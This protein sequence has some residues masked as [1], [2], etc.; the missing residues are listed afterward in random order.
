MSDK[1]TI[2]HDR[3]HQLSDIHHKLTIKLLHISG[4]FN[5]QYI[6]SSQL[7]E[8]NHSIDQ[9]IQ[10]LKS[11]KQQSINNLHA[12]STLYRHISDQQHSSLPIE[13]YV[14]C[15][16]YTYDKCVSVQHST[17]L[18]ICQ[19]RTNINCDQFIEFDVNYADIN[20]TSYVYVQVY[21]IQHNYTTQSMQHKCI[22]AGKFLL[23]DTNRSQLK[24]GK[25]RCV[26]YRDRPFDDIPLSPA[27]ITRQL[28]TL[29]HASTSNGHARSNS[30]NV[31]TNST[32]ERTRQ[33]STSSSQ[34]Q[35]SLIADNHQMD[36]YICKLVNHSLYDIV[37]III[38]MLQF[39]HNVLY[40]TN[41]TLR[42]PY[43]Q[44]HSVS[45]TIQNNNATIQHRIPV[46]VTVQSTYNVQ[47]Q[48]NIIHDPES[49]YDNT[50]ELM[51]NKLTRTSTINAIDL[52]PNRDER[53]QLNNII[54]S[55]QRRLTLDEKELLWRFRY[56]LTDNKHAL[57]KFLHCVNWN[58]NNE[59]VAACTLLQQWNN[60]IIEIS[61]LLEILNNTITTNVVVRQ[62][63]MNQ[64]QRISDTE[65]KL[66]LLQLIQACQ[67]DSIDITQP[68]SYTIVQNSNTLIS[69]L[70]QR[71]SNTIE[72]AT[73]FYWYIHIECID[74]TQSLHNNKTQLYKYVNELFH[75]ILQ[76]NEFGLSIA[77]IL[78]NQQ[79]LVF[80]LNSLHSACIM[81]GGNVST[82]IQRMRSLLQN[83]QLKHMDLCD[84]QSNI[85]MPV[86]P[87][88]SVTGL[89]VHN[90][91]MFKS[92]LAPMLLCFN[93]AHH[94]TTQLSTPAVNTTINSTPRST[95]GASRSSTGGGRLLTQPQQYRVIYK[96]GDDLRQDQLIVSMIRLIDSILQQI[97]LDLHLTPYNV[98]AVNHTAGFIEYISESYTLS[99]I[100]D[101]YKDIKSFISHYNSTEQQYKQAMNRYIR[102]CAGYCCITYILGVGDRHN[103]NI[104][105]CSDGRLFHIDFAYIFGRDPKPYATAMRCSVDMIQCMIDSNDINDKETMYYNQF[106]RYIVLCFNYIRQ[107]ANLILNMIALMSHTDIS[108]LN[109]ITIQNNHNMNSSSNT[110]N[111]AAEQIISK[112]AEKFRLDLSDDD[113]GVYILSLLDQSVSAVMPH[114]MD[115]VHK[116]ATYWR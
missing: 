40:N 19:D 79:Y 100:L 74:T 110:T 10:L 65:L 35:Q 54:H 33:N 108:D 14:Q 25:Q 93:V 94:S 88:I 103:D 57:I 32:Q 64:L 91:T 70:I 2:D 83:K 86:Q 36:T 114:I 51:Y 43:T 80:Q 115:V 81:N 82:R 105:L 90:T 73:Y 6:N 39:H 9:L 106:R 111:H 95:M 48:Y 46:P 41:N 87:H 107:H 50:I 89:V 92:A 58:D 8:Q 29:S 52:K 44:L 75:C 30:T 22:A 1:V 15:R 53:L 85:V 97:K 104:L 16:L 20:H 13:I 4:L 27:P 102:S 101:E 45:Y 59:S 55:Y 99:Y 71:C 49:Q 31:N 66:Y 116:W 47:H 109:D 78:R 38:D 37:Y 23:I 5:P 21:T 17:P 42:K 68:V 63:A 11:N 24:L 12:I 98:I 18:I 26:L 28:R 112:I 60:S 76:Y 69:Y 34:H 61:D 67:F 62:Y 72:L 84:L 3:Y 7:H 56:S 77:D 113:A 96:V